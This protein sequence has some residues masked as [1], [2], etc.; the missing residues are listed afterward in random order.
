MW[1]VLLQ[2]DR[3]LNLA[4]VHTGFYL[5]YFKTVLDFH[6]REVSYGHT[7]FT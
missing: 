7:D 1:P 4:S 3:C 6:G 5:G 2:Y